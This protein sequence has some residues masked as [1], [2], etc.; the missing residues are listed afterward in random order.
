MRMHREHDQEEEET[1]EPR[2]ELIRLRRPVV[3][4]SDVGQRVDGTM[5]APQFY[6]C[7][8]YALLSGGNDEM[9]IAVGVSSANPG[10]GKTLVACNLAISLTVAY[11]R[12]TVLVDLNVHKP[13]LHEV[14]DVP[15]GPGLLEAVGDGAIQ[16]ARTTI[17]DLYVLTAGVPNGRL[18]GGLN[19]LMDDA[20]QNVEP[21]L[22][23]EQVAA[24][25]DVL[26]S[27][28]GAFSFVVVDMPAVREHLIPLLFTNQLDGVLF[29]VHGGATKQ[30]DLDHALQLINERRVLGF[31][32]N[33]AERTRPS[34]K[35]RS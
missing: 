27:L 5:V 18:G 31:V 24:F 25:R 35:R 21:S 12:K 7:F 19:S 20:N 33:G 1:P 26:Y 9:N 11:Q 6:D 15:I 28:K 13:R 10:E 2:G 16:V 30:A 32:Y 34:R 23:L 17:S 22:Q 4:R 14:F 29:V 8:N 3:F